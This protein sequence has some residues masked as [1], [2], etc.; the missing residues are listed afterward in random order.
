MSITDEGFPDTPRGHLQR[1]K[2]KR[3]KEKQ[4]AAT[5]TGS[6]KAKRKKK[7]GASTTE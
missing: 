2:L 4:D 7:T 5:G 6:K 3:L 1:D